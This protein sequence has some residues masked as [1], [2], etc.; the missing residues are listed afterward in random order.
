[1]SEFIVKPLDENTWPDFA[2]LVEKHNGVWG[3]WLKAIPRTSK[4]DR[5]QHLFFT[6]GR[7]RCLS[8][9]GFNERVDSER[10]IG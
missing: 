3:G 4:V 6:M 9:R 1:M 7:S 2:R 10:T 8:V 5:S